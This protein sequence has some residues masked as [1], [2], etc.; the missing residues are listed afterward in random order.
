MTHLSVDAQITFLN[1]RDLKVTATFY[2]EVMEFPLVLDQGGCRIYEAAPN[3]YLGFCERELVTSDA[4]IIFT[5]VTDEVDRWYERLVEAKIPIEKAPA[6]NEVYGIYHCFAR[7]PNGY[8][9]EIQEFLDPN[10]HILGLKD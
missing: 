6:I 8:R 7:D 1:T 5:I 2:E 3:A 4:G 10:W 9:I